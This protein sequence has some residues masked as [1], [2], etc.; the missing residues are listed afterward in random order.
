MVEETVMTARWKQFR[1]LFL[2][3]LLAVPMLAAPRV[4]TAGTRSPAQPGTINYVEGQ[5]SL[6]QQPLSQSSVGTML[7]AGQTLTTTNGRVEILLTPGIFLRLDN[8]TTVR[9]DT[10]G[11]AN[12]TVTLVSGRAMV[13]VADIL[14][15][16]Y[17]ILNENGASVRLIKRGLYQF[18]ATAGQVRAYD[19]Q[20]DVTA[21]GRTIK[22]D[23]GHELAL[24]N[25]PKYKTHG[26]DKK[27]QDDF[28]RWSSLRASYLAEANRSAA[29]MYYPGGPGWYGPD[30][31]W[32]PSYDAY[33]WIPGDGMFWDPFGWG[34]YSPWYLGFGFG[35]G[36]G[37]YGF[38][39]GGYGAGRFGGYHRFGPGYR[40]GIAQH[41]AGAF[42]RSA[43]GGYHAVG[44]GGGAYRG[45]GFGGGG[46]H[47][48]GFGGGGFHGGGG[49]GFHGGGGGGGRR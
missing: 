47:G 8:G 36:Y 49:G 24:I 23:G 42:G 17:V 30:W 3:G 33:T 45:G 31:Y 25:N 32:D 14:P 9:V 43:G 4:P 21:G 12:D 39:Y 5:A 16:N 2:A 34:F 40:P 28:Y 11:L 26:F 13:E 1:S 15:A 22:L 38:G 41:A 37:G 19:G 7:Q 48:G 35:F 29:Q 44:F 20:A 27:E 46:F 6:N 10:F 18:D